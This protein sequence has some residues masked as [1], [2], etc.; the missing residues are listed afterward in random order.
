MPKLISIMTG[1]CLVLL[2]LDHVEGRGIVCMGN[3]CF[4]VRAMLGIVA[5]GIVGLAIVALAVV[6]IVLKL[7]ELCSPCCGGKV[8]PA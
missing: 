3:T 1:L 8:E 6:Y 4:G 7:G 2:F 5:G